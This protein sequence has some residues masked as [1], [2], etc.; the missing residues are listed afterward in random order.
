MKIDFWK[1]IDPKCGHDPKILAC[2]GT[3]IDVSTRNLNLEHP[4]TKPDHDTVLKSN[5]GRKE[6]SHT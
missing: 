2:D 3:H 1:E 5:H 4:V 6:S